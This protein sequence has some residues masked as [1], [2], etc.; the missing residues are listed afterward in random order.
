MA[1]S[2][3][4]HTRITRPKV[5]TVEKSRY[6][7]NRNSH[8]MKFSFCKILLWNYTKT[9]CSIYR[10]EYRMV[11]LCVIHI[12]TH[13][14]KRIMRYIITTSNVVSLYIKKST[15]FHHEHT[16]FANCIL[17]PLCRIKPPH[18]GAVGLQTNLN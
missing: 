6:F 14:H 15:L 4:T 8:T 3:S 11:F 7:L 16:N 1:F 13:L 12:H 10:C 18:L 17:F 5:N 2:P 9:S